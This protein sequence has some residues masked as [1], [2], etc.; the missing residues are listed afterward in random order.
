[1]ASGCTDFLQKDRPAFQQGT[2][3]CGTAMA[4]YHAM[5]KKTVIELPLD[6]GNYRQYITETK[7]P[8]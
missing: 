2:R 3:L 7:I 4:G 6:I 5:M 8:D 1:V